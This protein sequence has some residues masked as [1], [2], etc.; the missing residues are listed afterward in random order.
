VEWR[1]ERDGF[2]EYELYD[3]SVDPD[4]NTNVAGDPQ[5]AEILTDLRDRLHAGWKSEIPAGL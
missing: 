5:Y 2:V 3:H 4:E 1:A